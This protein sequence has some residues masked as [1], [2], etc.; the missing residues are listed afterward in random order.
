M[1]FDF[2]GNNRFSLSAL[3]LI[4]A[5]PVAN[6]DEVTDLVNKGNK[7]LLSKEYSTAL[8]QYQIAEGILP[9]SP[10]LDYNI[11]SVLYEQGK[12]EESIDRFKK[13]LGSEESAL[14]AAAHY[15]LGNSFY[16]SGDYVKAIESYQ[17]ALGLDPDDMDAKFN[18]ELA[19]KMLKENSKP[20]DSPD[21]DKNE[22]Q[23]Q[24]Q[25]EQKQE[26]NKEEQE[27]NKDEQDQKNQQEQDQQDKNDQEKKDKQKQQDEKKMS[28]EDAERILNALR[29]DEQKQQEKIRRMRTSGDYTGE[30]W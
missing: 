28:K 7:A 15:N 23:Q 26:E 27:Q 11:A 18:L 30:D 19:R 29:D 22:Q 9:G 5:A 17:D 3:L 24:E 13:S 6:A 12:Y 1:R 4:L 2:L 25:D 10:E 20:E 14:Q 8:D 21:K 16:R